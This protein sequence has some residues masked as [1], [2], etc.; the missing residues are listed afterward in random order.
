VQ[1]VLVVLVLLLEMLGTQEQ[2]LAP[3]YF[4]GHSQAPF[5]CFALEQL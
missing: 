4:A 5:R 3:E 2:S 1:P